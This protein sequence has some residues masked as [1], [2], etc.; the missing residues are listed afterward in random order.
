MLVRVGMQRIRY[1]PFDEL[2]QE[3]IKWVKARD[4]KRNMSNIMNTGRLLWK[5]WLEF[6]N[7]TEDDLK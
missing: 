5:D 2:K 6:F 1:V 7:I 4:K 3:A